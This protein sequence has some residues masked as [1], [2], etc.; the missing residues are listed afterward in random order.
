MAMGL[1]VKRDDFCGLDYPL[2]DYADIDQFCLTCH[3]AD[4]AAAIN[5]NA[6]NNGVNRSVSTRALYFIVLR[7]PRVRY[8][9]KH[10]Q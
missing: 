8:S 2:S 4:G 10:M 7:A 1:G 5:V 9:R 3:D 6:T